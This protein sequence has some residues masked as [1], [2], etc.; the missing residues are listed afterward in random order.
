M[1]PKLDPWYVTGLA[2]GI[3]GFTYSRS[4]NTIAPYFALKV[5]AIDL[6]ILQ[7]IQSF[8]G[9]VGRIYEIKPARGD[10][11]T[12]NHSLAYFRVT[13]ATELL[14]VVDHFDRYPLIGAR[15]AGYGIWRNMVSLKQR[16]RKPDLHKFEQLAVAL[17]ALSPRRKPRTRLRFPGSS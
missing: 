14:A 13:R 9:G 4:D 8:F 12:A 17:S 6:S 7:A 16:F 5:G 1:E 3:G 10:A 2:D 15:A 11:W